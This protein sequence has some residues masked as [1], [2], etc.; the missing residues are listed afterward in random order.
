MTTKCGTCGKF[1]S[2]VTDAPKCAICIHVFHPKC[3]GIKA[4]GPIPVKW[5]CK[6]CKQKSK[7]GVTPHSCSASP[8]NDS[9]GEPS[10]GCDEAV[11]VGQE[12]KLIRTQLAT[13]IQHL[14]SCQQEMCNFKQEVSK[15]NSTMA[16]F[17]KRLSTAE[18]NLNNVTKR[19]SEV[20]SK[21]ADGSEF[22]VAAEVERR[23]NDRDQEYYSTDVEISGVEELPDENPVHIVTVLAQKLGVAVDQ[24][25]IVYV[26]RKGKRGGVS[27]GSVGGAGT[28]DQDAGAR[29]RT[30]VVRLARHALRNDLLRAARLRRDVDTT[31]IVASGRP[32]RF[33]VNERLTWFNRRLFHRVRQEARSRDWRFAWCRE[34]RIYVRRDASSK[35]LRIRTEADVGKIFGANNS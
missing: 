10:P 25:E 13:I 32:R 26:Q 19:L 17:N 30:L 9:T 1:V 24:R 8:D 20:E 27:G 15:I 7:K 16:E 5:T 2:S 28:A 4:D 3:V 6:N 35:A 31:G 12:I 34:G 23:L 33:F 11:N 22:D 21:L 18:G 14:T 29:P